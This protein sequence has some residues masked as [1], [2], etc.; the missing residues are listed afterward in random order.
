MGE[1][2]QVLGVGVDRVDQAQAIRRITERIAA[3]RAGQRGPLAHVVTANSEIIMMAA[4]DAQMA[5][6][7]AKAALVTPDGA[8]VVWAAGYLG[9]P[10]P[11]RVAGIDLMWEVLHVCATNG[12]RP[13]FLGSAPGVA[14]AAIAALQGKIPGLQVAGSRH[15]Y[16]TAAEEAAVLEQINNSGTDLLLVAL[17]APRQEKW[18]AAHREQL[19]V[20]VAVG[21][22]GSLD[23][24]AGRTVRA[25]RWM[26]DAGLEW[27]YRLMRQPQRALRMMA[28]PRFAL[29]VIWTKWRREPSN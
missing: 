8:G 16:F 18:I 28:L 13:F 20:P 1:R 14:E 29:R 7:L 2:V 12:W 27:A 24:W 25:P 23:I 19:H 9:Q 4:Q 26:C 5:D 6:I 3:W 17:G 22:G 11:E 10:V 15:G 21:V